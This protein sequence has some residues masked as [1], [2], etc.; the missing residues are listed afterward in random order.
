MPS[1]AHLCKDST[2]E[3]LDMRVLDRS[4]ANIFALEELPSIPNINRVIGLS[5]VEGITSISIDFKLNVDVVISQGS[6]LSKKEFVEE[7]EFIP[8]LSAIQGLLIKYDMS[9]VVFKDGEAHFKR[10]R[11]YRPLVDKE[12]H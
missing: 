12:L 11:Y 1:Q 7:I 3:N 9:F 8:K 4:T 2:K 10:S 5:K 6:N